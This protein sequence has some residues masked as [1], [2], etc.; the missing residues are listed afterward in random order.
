MTSFYKTRANANAQIVIAQIIAKAAETGQ[1]L[2]AEDIAR[3]LNVNRCR[4]F[5][6]RRVGCLLRY[7][8]DVQFISKGVWRP[9]VPSD[10][11]VPA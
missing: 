8:T 5:S 7:R 2:H 3:A 6:S 4:S 10:G 1:D 11:G 9:V